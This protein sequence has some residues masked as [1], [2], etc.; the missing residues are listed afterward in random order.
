MR[1]FKM[2]SSRHAATSVQ[3]GSIDIPAFEVLYRA[4]A[5]IPR[6][7]LTIDFN[8]ALYSTKP[9]LRASA[10]A[11]I[12]ATWNARLRANPKLFNGSKFR[13][14]SISGQPHT[15]LS[16]GIGLSDYASYLGTNRNDDEGFVME[17]QSEGITRF[18]NPSALLAHPFGNAALIITSD[19]QVPVVRR[20][21]AHTAEFAG[22][23]D[24][25]GKYGDLMYN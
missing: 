10:Q 19:G 4:S 12:Q 24:V 14:N 9:P 22:W 25:P 21:V 15:T 5:P 18:N 11:R 7:H 17:L 1:I 8:P 6:H 16:L 23:W 2:A 13:L 3:G 20:S